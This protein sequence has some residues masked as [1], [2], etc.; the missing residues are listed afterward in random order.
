MKNVHLRESIALLGT[1]RFGTFWFASLLSNIGTWAQQ[2][3][4]PWLLLSLGASPFLL[5]LD[6]FALGAPTLMLILVGGALADRADR[7]R[8]IAFFQSIQMLCPLILVWLLIT[9]SVEPWIV[10]V[11][12]L[13]VGITDA[14]SMPSFQ[15]I[16][17]SIVEREQIASGIALNSTQFN[18][19]R[20][21]GPALAGVLMAS[22]GMAGAFAV[23]AASYV[24]FILVALW[25]L[26]RTTHRTEVAPIP[27]NSSGLWSNVREV[28]SDASLRGALL[29]VLATAL[30]CAPV[31]TFTPLL[32]KEVFHGGSSQFSTA[33]GA[34]GIGGLIGAT[35]LMAVD[36]KSDRRFISTHF[37]IA[38]AIVVGLIAFNR[39]EWG[40][41]VLMVM[42]GV[43]M[44][45]SN[46]SANALIQSNAPERI[47]GQSV[48]L[49]MLAMRG[50]MALGSLLTGLMVHL[51]GVQEALLANGVIALITHLLIRNAWLKVAY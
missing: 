34:F 12:S 25:V 45:S 20:I 47:R 48:S 51:I 2:M 36:P 38:F 3:A 10:I 46:A 41:P 37:A 50:G 26:P 28:V 39:W 19:S 27:H 30:L 44:T 4:Q 24:P 43:A 17:P 42:A 1:K 14:L 16:V 22:V 21:L 11:L 49:F 29:T 7:R 23:S 15:S 18:L 6:A 35:G 32:V 8:T 33:L 5:G 9:G 40:L 13:I 31:V